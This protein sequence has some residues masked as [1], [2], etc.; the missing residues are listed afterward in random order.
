M[1]FWSL[2]TENL[3]Q[4]KQTVFD[5]RHIQPTLNLHFVCYVFPSK[6]IDKAQYH[7]IGY[8]DIKIYI[9]FSFELHKQIYMQTVVHK[10]KVNDKRLV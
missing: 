2:A 9:I 4:E 1:L 5:Q 7:A 8:T 3:C 10:Y 6:L